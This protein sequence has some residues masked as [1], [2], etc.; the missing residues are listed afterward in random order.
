MPKL[1]RLLN[2]LVLRLLTL[3][4]LLK[5]LLDLR[6]LR[7]LRPQLLML[8]LLM[9]KLRLLMLK[10]LIRKLP[11]R[12]LKFPIRKLKLPIRKLK[13]LIRKLPIR[14]LPIRKLP[15]RRLKFLIRRLKLLIR[16]LLIHR[17]KLKL[18]VHRLNLKLPVRRLKLKLPVRRRKPKPK[19]LILQ[20]LFPSL[21]ILRRFR[22]LPIL[23]LI[24][25]TLIHKLL[26]LQLLVLK[27]LRKLSILKLL[28]LN[29]KLRVLR[30]KHIFK[31][32]VPRLLRK[33]PTPKSLRLNLL[34][35]RLLILWLLHKLPTL[36]APVLKLKLLSLRHLFPTLLVLRLLCKLPSLRLLSLKLVPNLNLIL[37]LLIWL[38]HT[39]LLIQS[40]P[41]HTRLHQSNPILSRHKPHRE[42]RKHRETIITELLH[43]K[44]I[45]VSNHQSPNRLLDLCLN[46]SQTL[47]RRISKETVLKLY[48]HLDH[49]SR[50]PSLLK[51]HLIHL[52]T[53][54]SLHQGSHRPR[55][56][57]PSMI[58]PQC[59][60]LLLQQRPALLG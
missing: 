6:L 24:L 27:L 38:L 44:L 34:D 3:K 16:K 29:L 46:L 39:H 56:I 11:I 22:K 26:L 40:P 33:P 60:R 8:K 51:P 35:L 28:V 19:L 42:Q 15:I 9:F 12:R 50:C 21:I 37:R 31:L 30:L 18:P 53:V 49:D 10:P 17:L 54:M 47:A 52:Q 7:L 45:R 58:H 41:Q 32:P 59:P 13:L 1:K 14:K 5:L 55:R 48:H 20:L 4:L 36:E 57:G 2:L 23:K 25:R 43:L